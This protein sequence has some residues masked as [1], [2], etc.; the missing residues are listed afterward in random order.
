MNPSDHKDS[1]PLLLPGDQPSAPGNLSALPAYIDDAALPFLDVLVPTRVLETVC[2][3]AIS[4]DPLYYPQ[5]AFHGR[6]IYFC[7]G[8]CQSV[9]LSDPERFYA[10]HSKRTS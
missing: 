4:G 2:H 7:T 9:F 6:T 10:A 1:F 3:R 5:A 8:T